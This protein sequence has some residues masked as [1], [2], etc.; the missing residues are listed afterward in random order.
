MEFYFLLC[1][2]LTIPRSHVVL[3]YAR[4]VRI[5]LDK[6]D[7]HRMFSA[8]FFNHHDQHPAPPEKEPP[9]E[10][11]TDLQIQNWRLRGVLLAL[12]EERERAKEREAVL[13]E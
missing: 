1:L 13:G 8:D 12:G 5:D 2:C 6:L 4:S 3:P 10:K 11:I 9:F 7:S